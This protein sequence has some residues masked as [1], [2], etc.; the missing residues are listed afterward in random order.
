MGYGVWG[1]QADDQCEAFGLLLYRDAIQFCCGFGDWLVA[2]V[3][4]VVVISVRASLRR[5]E[6]LRYGAIVACDFEMLFL[7][8]FPFCSESWS[9]KDYII[10]S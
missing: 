1:L 3:A 8:R 9:S 2:A 4:V 6:R 10:R 5:V 7:I